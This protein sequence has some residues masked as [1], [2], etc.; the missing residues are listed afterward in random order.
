DIEDALTRLLAG[1]GLTYR[2]IDARTVTLVPRDANK[3]A[4]SDASGP[5][6]AQQPLRLARAPA[7]D[8]IS[9]GSVDTS[10]MD[11][12]AIEMVIVTGTRIQRSGFTTPTPVT[13]VGSEDFDARATTNIADYLNDLPAFLPTQ[14]P[15]TNTIATGGVGNFLNLRGL[16]G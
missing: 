15:T 5:P 10:E 1:S 8:S 7:N 9:S 13:V 11:R 12:E 6:I 3:Q 2:F 16:G 14:T 4:T